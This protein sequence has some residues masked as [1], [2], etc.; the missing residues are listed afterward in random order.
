MLGCTRVKAASCHHSRGRLRS[1][2]RREAAVE[3]ATMARRNHAS[4]LQAAEMPRCDAAHGPSP[5][6]EQS[7]TTPSRAADTPSP[8]APGCP[9]AHAAPASPLRAARPSTCTPCG[10]LPPSPAASAFST[11]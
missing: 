10:G 7:P 6:V 1:C 2:P 9:P 11:V 4:D 5:R 8:P 3:V